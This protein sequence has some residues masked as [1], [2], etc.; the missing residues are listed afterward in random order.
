MGELVNAARDFD[1]EQGAQ[2]EA[3]EATDGS[4][5]GVTGFLEQTRLFGD[6]D[7][8]EEPQDRITLMTLHAAK[9]LEFPIVFIV[10]IEEGIL[11]L[12]RV[13]QVD[14]EEERRLL[15]VGLTRAQ[16]RLHL[17]HVQKRLRFGDLKFAYPSKFFGEMMKKNAADAAGEAGSHLQ[18]DSAT[19]NSLIGP[20]EEVSRSEARMLWGRSHGRDEYADDDFGDGDLG[21]DFGDD[22]GL[23]EDP[24]PVGSRIYHDDY[25]EGTISRVSR[26]GRR[27]QVTVDF[28]EAGEKRLFPAFTLLRRLR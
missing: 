9:G 22:L 21:D 12:E 17:S 8:S 5:E 28:D 15:Y 25:G 3:R 27:A 20:G 2:P 18:V 16:E 14:I 10:A 24:Y 13:D 23:D 26:V 19:W 1:R 6:V 4:A 7:R 11:P